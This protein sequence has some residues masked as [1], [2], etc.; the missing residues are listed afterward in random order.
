MHCLE[1]KSNISSETLV[2]LFRVMIFLNHN[3][4]KFLKFYQTVYPLFLKK[5]LQKVLCT[6]KALDYVQM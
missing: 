4:N 3:F 5:F 2:S 1:N 6:L